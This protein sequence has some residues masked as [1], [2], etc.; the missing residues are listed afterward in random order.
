MTE[1]PISDK[2]EAAPSLPASSPLDEGLKVW[3]SAELLGDAVEAVIL[4]RG[5]RYR[6]RCTKQGKLI[7]YK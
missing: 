5:Q 4:H 6:L 3:D 1:P 2:P 7:L